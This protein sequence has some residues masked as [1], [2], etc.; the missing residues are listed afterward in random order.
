M[1][2]G[3]QA[4]DRRKTQSPTP[5]D[6]YRVFPDRAQRSKAA[7]PLAPLAGRLPATIDCSKADTHSSI[8]HGTTMRL[9]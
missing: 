9:V 5:I 8:N 1:F 3:Q 7:G 4:L 2:F 6:D